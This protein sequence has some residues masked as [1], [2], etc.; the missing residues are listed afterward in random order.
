MSVFTIVIICLTTADGPEWFRSTDE[1][2]NTWKNIS[3]LE[4]GTTYEVRIKATN[5]DSSVAS[6]I[7]EVRTEGIGEEKNLICL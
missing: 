1:V 2:I 6:G 3:N 4:P 5:G 7:E